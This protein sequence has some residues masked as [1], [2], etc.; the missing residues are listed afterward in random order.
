MCG[1]LRS[2]PTILAGIVASFRLLESL[3]LYKFIG[4]IHNGVGLS[5]TSIRFCTVVQGQGGSGAVVH[6]AILK[7]GEE[8]RNAFFV[9]FFFPKNLIKEPN[10]HV[11]VPSGERCPSC[12]DLLPALPGLCMY[13]RQLALSIENICSMPS[14]QI[15]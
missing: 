10:R 13:V 1:N 14:N 12:S 6:P 5:S 11:R 8:S 15:F 7:G 4:S 9:K 2:V 3:R